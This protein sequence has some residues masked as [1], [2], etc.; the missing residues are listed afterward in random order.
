M[1]FYLLLFL[2][3]N[4]K[5][6]SVKIEIHPILVIAVVIAYV[7]NKVV[8]KILRWIRKNDV[9]INFLAFI[10]KLMRKNKFYTILK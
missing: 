9:K 7:I 6:I 4:T 2:A 5:M 3:L 10:W 1:I 8:S